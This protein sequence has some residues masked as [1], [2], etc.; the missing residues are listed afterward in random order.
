MKTHSLAVQPINRSPLKLSSLIFFIYK[1]PSLNS[2]MKLVPLRLAIL[3][4]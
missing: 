1:L 3:T 4:S 2:L